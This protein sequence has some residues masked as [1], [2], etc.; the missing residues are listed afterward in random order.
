MKRTTAKSSTIQPKRTVTSQLSSSSNQKNRNLPEKSEKSLPVSQKKR[1]IPETVFN[2]TDVQRSLQSGM[3]GC[4]YMCI[5]IF[6][7]DMV[8]MRCVYDIWEIH[9]HIY[10][11][12][13]YVC[14]YTYL[15][16]YIYIRMCKYIYIC[17]YIIYMYIYI[18]VYI[19]MYICI[20]ICAHIY[21]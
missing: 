19:Y 14:I 6:I 18:H 13:I 7:Y 17:I 5:C 8:D 15:Y 16:I 10:D 4:M 2:L 21:I 20:C 12:C 11:S 9:I 3:L 1:D